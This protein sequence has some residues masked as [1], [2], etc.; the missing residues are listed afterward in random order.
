[1]LAVVTGASSAVAAADDVTLPDK[2]EDGRPAAL[3]RAALIKLALISVSYFGGA[4]PSPE[5]VSPSIDPPGQSS[6]SKWAA[7]R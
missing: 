1:M 4:N 2:R 3:S 6:S 5:V 7:S